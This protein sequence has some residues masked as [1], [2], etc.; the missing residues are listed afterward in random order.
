MILDPD[1]NQTG[2]TSLR[3][4]TGVSEVRWSG[5]Q[6]LF[7]EFGTG[8]TGINNPY[9]DNVVMG[10]VS[11][12]P[13]QYHGISGNEYWHYQDEVTGAFE[14]TYGV[15]AYAPMYTVF[16]DAEQII[17][18][19]GFKAFV[20]QKVSGIISEAFSKENIPVQVG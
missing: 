10:L 11:Y 15:P 12:Q 17:K 16:L 1:G 9:P 8:I 7:L 3:H 14:K 13:Q 18:A 19:G 5:D 6:I 2:T 4:I 20:E